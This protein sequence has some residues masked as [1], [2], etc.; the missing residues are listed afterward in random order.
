MEIAGKDKSFL[1]FYKSHVEF[2]SALN[3]GTIE[4]KDDFEKNSSLSKQY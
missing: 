1:V 2:Q 3:L 4:T